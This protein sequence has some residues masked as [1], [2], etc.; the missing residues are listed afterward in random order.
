MR[1]PGS[2]AKKP[3]TAGSQQP[4]CDHEEHQIL[5]A[6]EATAFAAQFWDKKTHPT[7]ASQQ[8]FLATCIDVNLEQNVKHA[9]RQKYTRKRGHQTTYFVPYRGSRR[10]ICKSQFLHYFKISRIVVESVAKAKAAAAVATPLSPMRS[11]QKQAVGNTRRAAP[12]KLR[13]EKFLQGLPQ[14]E[15]RFSD[16]ARANTD[17]VH[18]A[19]VGGRRASPYNVWIHW[20]QNEE[21]DQF[22]KRGKA[23]FQPQISLKTAQRTMKTFKL[24]YQAPLKDTCAECELYNLQIRTAPPALKVVMLHPCDPSFSF[25]FVSSVPLF[26]AHFQAKLQHQQAT[27]L[28]LASE[29]YDR[30]KYHGQYSMQTWGSAKVTTYTTPGV[31]HSDRAEHIVLDYSKAMSLLKLPVGEKWYTSELKA[32]RLVVHRTT[33]GIDTVMVWPEYVAGKGFNETAS[34]L[35]GELY[36]CSTGAGH[37]FIHTDGCCSEFLNWNFCKLFDKLVQWRWFHRISWCIFIKGHSYNLCDAASRAMDRA[38]QNVDYYYGLTD[39]AGLTIQHVV[40]NKQRFV[41][42]LRILTRNDFWDVSRWLAGAYASSS[43]HLDQHKKPV[44]I[45]DHKI[46]WLDFGTTP[47]EGSLSPHPGFAWM[48]AGYSE[49][50][51]WRKVR[52]TKQ[53]NVDLTTDGLWAMPLNS[54]WVPVKSRRLQ[55]WQKLKK[56]VPNNKHGDVCPNGVP[57]LPEKDSANDDSE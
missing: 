53:R 28:R 38:L 55:D 9:G 39:M 40:R 37:L 48:K 42:K 8:E 50:I 23:D 11:P 24:G 46:K 14:A 34:A 7:K 47:D 54:G 45:R 52:L 33:V 25:F 16:A 1:E 6:S 2:R 43:D 19:P 5:S 49:S 13:F 29:G 18:L 26:F 51:E 22:A 15:N 57:A 30:N 20:L 56:Y 27:H 10:Q 21:P 32:H 12:V 35:I 3:R 36:R 4:A 41:R 17:T 31:R 44:L